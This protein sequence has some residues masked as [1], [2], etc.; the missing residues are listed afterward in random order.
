LGWRYTFVAGAALSACWVVLWLL[1]YRAPREH[2]WIG[3]DEIALIEDGKVTDDSAGAVPLSRLLRMPE[4]WGCILARLLTDPISYFFA[5]WMPQF[6]Q[7]ERGFDLADI[8]RYYW[9][10]YVASAIG[11]LAGGAIPRRLIRHGWSINRSR[12]TVMFAA[13]CLM[14][15]CFVLITKVPNPVYAVALIATAMFCHAAWAN[16]TLPAEV[17]P[18]RVVGTVAG[19]GGAAGSLVGAVTMV[20]IGRTVSVSS[21]TPI[22]IIYSA[23]PMT[24]FL[25]VCLLI[26]RLGEVRQIS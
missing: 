4:A 1:V 6:L 7:K 16:M 19:F 15:L 9:I 12:K 21:F 25:L 8:G 18:K 20:L 14:P 13:S 5:F 26:K 11:N 17:F 24:A 2:P 10:P 22:F 23:I 3:S